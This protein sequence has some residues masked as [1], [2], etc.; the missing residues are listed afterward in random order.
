VNALGEAAVTFLCRIG[1]SDALGCH[2]VVAERRHSAVMQAIFDHEITVDDFRPARRSLRVAVVTETWPPEINGVAATASRVVAE[3][4]E[5]G[6][7]L[8][9]IRPRQGPEDRAEGGDAEAAVPGY[10]EVLMRGLPIPRYPQL[11]M[12]LPS[13]RTLLRLWGRQR[14]DVVHIVTEGPLGWSALQAATALKLPVVSD[15]RTNFHAY[16]R[17]YGV[18]WLHKPIVAYLRK[19]HNRCACTMVPTPG[20]RDE[21]SAL[22]LRELRVV[23]RGVDA[24]LFD[25]ARRSLA[26]RRQWGVADD[27]PVVVHVG[28]LAPEKNLDTLVAAYEAM[29]QVNPRTAL[30]FV[31]DGPARA[32]LAARCP[33]AHFAGLQRG[34]AL[35]AHYASADVFLFP[36]L[37][38]T[39]GN[40]LPEA[41]ASGL[42]VLAFD[43]AAAAQLLGSRA[44]PLDG[45]GAGGLVVPFGDAAAFVAS[46]A[47]LAG[48]PARVAA[49]RSQARR[50]AQALDWGRI[51]REVEREYLAALA[52]ARAAL[53]SRLDPRPT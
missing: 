46:A 47:A 6:H 22:G 20:L 9:V 32:S 26:L 18:A 24:A 23:A 30:V 19:F 52:P 38:E 33:G 21:L 25:P 42:A 53:G 1:C 16:S 15:F 7:E 10:A 43:Y 28:R 39:Y 27:D 45:G 31:G 40:V 51:A 11:K 41:L 44:A 17:H 14:P 12:G 29:R 48:D 50:V 34:E 13:R 49:L 2:Q 36:S 3:L 35:A 5:R 8:Q 4:R 37:T